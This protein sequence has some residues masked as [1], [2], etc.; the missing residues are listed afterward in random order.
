MVLKVFNTLTRKKDVFKPLNKGEVRMYSCG[1]TLYAPPHIGNM[2]SFVVSDLIRRYLEFKGFKVK[3]VMNLT[4]IDDKTIRDSGAEG[5]SLKEFT[6]R[7]TKLF[8]DSIDLLNIKQASAYP[9]AT[10]HF[11][12]MIELVRGLVKKGVAYE[13]SGSVYYNISKFKKY[14]KLAKLDLKGMKIGATIDADEYEK[15][16]PRDFVLLK[17]STTEELKREIFYK[18]EWGNVRPGWHLECSVLS[19]KYLGETFDIHS[20]GVDLI[21]P[22][23]ENE[24]AQSEAYTGKEFVRYWIHNEHL[25]VNGQKMSKSLGNYITLDE[26]L[27]KFSPEIVRYMFVSVHYRQKLNYTEEFGKNAEKNYNKLK[28]TFDKLN[29]SLKSAN[30]KKS[31]ANEHLLEK[32]K[33]LRKRFEEV[34]DDDLNTPLA[35]SVFHELS[36]EINKYLEKGKSKKAIQKAVELFKEFSEVFGLKFEEEVEPPEEI[37]DLIEQREKARKKNDWKTADGIRNKIKE[38]GYTIEDTD[39]GVKCKKIKNK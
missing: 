16:N 35:L 2:R 37:E 7:W 1:P 14:G 19:M 39:S 30:D 8:F 27:E 31:K 26:L 33:T 25:I 9:K 6:D 11:E 24:I 28:E 3:L 5:V 36:K 12:D 29:F 21:F 32:M 34:M 13:K 17:R 15:D 38:L 10:E 18:S 4:D 23:N 20:G 22:H